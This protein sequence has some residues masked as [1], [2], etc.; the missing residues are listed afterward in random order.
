MIVYL[1]RNTVNGK[2]YVGQTIASLEHRW[3]QHKTD[4]RG[5][6]TNSI[7]HK[8]IRKY[9]EDVFEFSVLAETD[10]LPELSALE[11]EHISKQGT[12]SP[13]GYN[14]TIGGQQGYHGNHSLE[15]RLKM[16]LA[17]KGTK[18]SPEWIA[19]AAATRIGKKRSPETKARMTAAKLG[20]L[21]SPETKDKISASKKGKPWS[22]KRRSS[23][24]K[25]KFLTSR[26]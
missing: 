25:R 15:A 18:Q 11:I 23:Q 9:G 20:H 24:E 19:N 16:S 17:R 3:A 12:L 21:V 6:S 22:A 7:L 5:R 2:G 26:S 1:I 13:G 14:L 4:A 8:A 10:N